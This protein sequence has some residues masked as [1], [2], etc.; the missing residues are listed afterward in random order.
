MTPT[1]PSP[2]AWDRRR[3]GRRAV[4]SPNPVRWNHRPRWWTTGS[5]HLR[6]AG[7][8]CGAGRRRVVHN[9]DNNNSIGRITSR[10]RSGA[11]SP[12]MRSPR[13]VMP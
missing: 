4:G 13:S 2:A 11:G 12:T 1:R 9:P 10:R 7:D 6:A 8:S 5:E 3:G